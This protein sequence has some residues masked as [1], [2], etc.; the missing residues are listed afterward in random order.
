MSEGGP[1]GPSGSSGFAQPGFEGMDV[2]ASCH[3]S[4]ASRSRP[5]HR[6]RSSRHPRTRHLRTTDEPLAPIN[7]VARVVILVGAMHFSRPFS[8]LV[9]ARLSGTAVPGARVKVPF[10]ARTVEGFVWSRE[11]APENA[12]YA[13]RPIGSVICP[14]RLLDYAQRRDM[15]AI[16]R[17]FGGTTAQ[18]L[19]LAVPPRA[20]RV[21]RER[22]WASV[23]S[24]SH[25]R[26]GPIPLPPS[27]GAA[28]RYADY[29]RR[30]ERSDYPASSDFLAL[31]RSS[32][33]ENSHSPGPRQG[34]EGT[35]RASRDPL[36]TERQDAPRLADAE[37]RIIWDVLPGRL[38][39]ADDM[40]WAVFCAFSA[41][42][43]ALVVL[44]GARQVRELSLRLE[45]LGLARLSAPSGETAKDGRREP[46]ADF[47]VLDSSDTSTARYR[48]Y[49]ALAS[50]LVRCVI[51]TRAAMYAPV[52]LGALFAVMDDNAYQNSDGDQPYANVRDVLALR[53]G[54]HHG[55]FL[56]MG[57]SRSP[58]SQQ[59]AESGALEV[60]GSPSVLAA[61]QPKSEWLTAE[62][63]RGRG[64]V[65]AS[66]RI[67]HTAVVAM[68]EALARGPV[69]VVAGLEGYV[70]VL[71]CSQCHRQARCMRCSGPL[72][73]PGPGEP[74]VC[75]WCGA[76]AVK[77]SCR[78]CGGGDYRPVRIGAQ[79]TAR[80]VSTL[81]R[82]VPIVVSVPRSQ[83][84]PRGP[85]D[86]IDASPRIVVATPSAIPDV[87]G[88]GEPETE[89]SQGYQ[90]CLI[91]DAWSSGFN[92]HLDARPD[93]LGLWMGIATRVV[94]GP[95]G[96]RLLLV[97]DCDE[98]LAT[99][100]MRWDPRLLARA[101]LS[102]R[103][104]A[105][106]P[107]AFAAASVWG[108]F[109]LVTR[110]LDEI[111]A[112]ADG[113]LPRVRVD[114][115]SL[116][117]VLGPIPIRLRETE[118]RSPVLEGSSDRVR[119]IVRVPLESRQL[120]ADRLHASVARMSSQRARGE[121][122]FWI[123]PKDLVER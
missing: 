77:W 79:G 20:S 35:S 119:A 19:S 65:T 66:S 101:E 38:R 39:W 28:E 14:L 90:A 21:E 46:A 84:F 12:E 81:V 107:P 62:T 97:G 27:G 52:G 82:G 114:G 123:D 30:T 17:F 72:R 86:R 7:P 70:D 83:R 116:P 106:L 10:G 71:G 8:Y 44:P 112:G 57:L 50:S 63:L 93:L 42:K 60:H 24:A 9:P 104:V 18:I 40:A 67:P 3:P 6:G 122:R 76:P 23:A 25:R 11:K 31:L 110:V 89:G 75:A 115:A 49:L 55:L 109:S 118:R 103:R 61:L 69:L 36:S 45:R 64:D 2:P 98:D 111:G 22:D 32:V 1:G 120:L 56:A 78:W 5:G 15:D 95:D 51:G 100:L 47:A 108:S 16:A 87:S 88:S 33:A 85:V 113:D 37:H 68:R 94:P 43:P 92:Q 48:S 34:P 117:S 102:D 105:G 13:L 91:L 73:L 59:D 4:A 121:I 26:F 58:A 53:A 99:S 41:G 96:G 80:E 74:A 29:L 54:E